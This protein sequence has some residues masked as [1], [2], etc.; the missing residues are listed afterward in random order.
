MNSILTKNQKKTF[1]AEYDGERPGERMLLIATVRYDDECGNGHNSFAIT[2]GIYSSKCPNSRDGVELSPSTGKTRG[3]AMGGC[4][5]EEIANHIPALRPFIKWHLVSSDAPLHYVANALY[6]AGHC[7][8]FGGP[9]KYGLKN[10]P[11]NWEY[12]KS[13]VVYGAAGGYDLDDAA[14]LPI[15]KAMTK[16]ELTAWL[17][18]RAPALMA[19]FRHDVEA[20]GF[21]Y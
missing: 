16:E 7:E 20:L 15:I 13:T 3:W 1:T 8:R 18:N 10:Y 4:V 5:H 12:F 2:G 9:D 6:H 14:E 21:V 17:N 19:A 11:A